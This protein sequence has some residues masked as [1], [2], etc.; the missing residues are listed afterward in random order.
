MK[1]DYTHISVILDRSGS[2][3]SIRDDTIGGFNTFMESQRSE[4]G[5][6]T[7][8]LVQFD[9]QDPYEVIHRFKPIQE[10]PELDHKT[11]QLR[12]HNRIY[13]FQRIGSA[14]G[15]RWFAR[16]FPN[17]SKTNIQL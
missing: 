5:T 6:A 1:Q 3:E 12:R 14:I 13:M 11:Y 8:T 4:P 17:F 10:V 15:N 16:K 9:T 7:L 2:M